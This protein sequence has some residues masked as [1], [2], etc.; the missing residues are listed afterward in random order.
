MDKTWI[1]IGVVV[2]LTI[3]II[4]GILLLG[5]NSNKNNEVVTNKIV[6]EVNTM[7]LQ[8]LL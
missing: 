5:N 3:G 2:I 1:I 8:I 6:N 7:L 4:A